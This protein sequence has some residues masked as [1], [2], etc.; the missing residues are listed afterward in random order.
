MR[1]NGSMRCADR[2]GQSGRAVC[3]AVAMAVASGAARLTA[4]QR[5]A[6]EELQAFS[7]VLNHVRVNYVDSV[8][9]A[10]LVHAA[11][12]GMLRALD[13]HSAFYSRLD[14][15]RLNAIERGELAV[16]GIVLEEID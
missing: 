14:Y 6:Y 12:D 16:T 3:C 13:P 5:S 4:Q 15:A 10:Q 9:Y 2:P 1:N 7:G 11:I 8:S